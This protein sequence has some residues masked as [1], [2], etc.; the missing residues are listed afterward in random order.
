MTNSAI[1]QVYMLKLLDQSVF[2]LI[3]IKD[4]NIPSFPRE[5]KIVFC[6]CF[7]FLLFVV[8]FLFFMYLYKFYCVFVLSYKVYVTIHN[9]VIYHRIY[10]WINTE[11]GQSFTLQNPYWRWIG[12]STHN[13]HH[14][15]TQ[16]LNSLLPHLI[17][18]K[19]NGTTYYKNHNKS[20]PT[21]YY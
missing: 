20:T 12:T 11:Q 19:Y 4:R 18:H 5:F 15:S 17:L 3:Y 1:M 2:S 10:A 6:V 8:V 14:I 9:G 21:H 16:H 13:T 7:V